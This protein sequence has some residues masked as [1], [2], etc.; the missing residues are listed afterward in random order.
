MHI[1]QRRE[2]GPPDSGKPERCGRKGTPAICFDT[3]TTFPSIRAASAWADQAGRHSKRPVICIETGEAFP[4]AA[5][6]SKRAGCSRQT[7]GNCAAGRSRTAGGYHW[8]YAEQPPESW[9]A[10]IECPEASTKFESLGDAA[11]WAGCEAAEI[12]D[13]LAGKKDEAGGVRWRFRKL[14]GGRRTMPIVCVETGD[15]FPSIKAAEEWAGCCHGTISA[16]LSGRSKTAGGYR[17]AYAEQ[18]EPSW[19]TPVTCLDTQMRFPGVK[20]AAA[21]AGCN[22]GCISAVLAGRAKTAGGRR[23]THTEAEAA[24]KAFSLHGLALD[25]GSLSLMS[26]DA[27]RRI[28]TRQRSRSSH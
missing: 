18:R 5:A 10:A 1:D 11:E 9:R 24:E 16:V 4:N 7:I 17:W 12:A 21:W 13:C 3:Q 8:A 20:E 27:L 15:E 28:D 23:W 6:A 25:D 26:E 22:P 19:K 14:R 2:P